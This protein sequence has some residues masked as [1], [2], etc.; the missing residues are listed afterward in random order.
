MTDRSGDDDEYSTGR[1]RH[2]G[3]WHGRC[4]C[5]YSTAESDAFS[6]GRR[7]PSESWLRHVNRRR[8]GNVR[9]FSFTSITYTVN[10]SP[11]LSAGLLDPVYTIQLKSDLCSDDVYSCR[12]IFTIVYFYCMVAVCQ[13]FIKLMID[14]LI[15]W[16]PVVKPVEQPFVSR[17]QT[18]NRLSNRLFNRFDNWLYRI[19]GVLLRPR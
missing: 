5:P 12:L 3:R 10:L 14:W 2:G 6:G 11:R 4:R 19:N 15:D 16:Q 18:F 1:V 9:L 17:I 13:P 8:A 7:Y